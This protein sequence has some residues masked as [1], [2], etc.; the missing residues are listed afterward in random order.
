MQL[1]SG[2][3]AL[4]RRAVGLTE[5]A[6]PLCRSAGEGVGV[7]ASPCRCPLCGQTF[8]VEEAEACAVCPLLHRCGLVMCPNCGYE[9]PPE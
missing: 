2:L 1:V 5:P 8:A 7:R 9:F 3:R 6:S 4:A